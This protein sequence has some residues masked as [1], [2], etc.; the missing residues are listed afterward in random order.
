MY[1]VEQVV[2]IGQHTSSGH[3]CPNTGYD[4]GSSISALPRE[5]V[6]G[7]YIAFYVE[8]EVNDISPGIFSHMLNFAFAYSKLD[9]IS[10]YMIRQLDDLSVL[11]VSALTFP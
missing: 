7:T 5:S 4:N 11:N 2:H 9:T 10:K 6:S 8:Y 1:G 3:D